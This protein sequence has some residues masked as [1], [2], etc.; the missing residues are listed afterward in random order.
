MVS[1][2]QFPQA[3]A[4]TPHS[5]FPSAVPAGAV[6]GSLG[7]LRW[8]NCYNKYI[9][10]TEVLASA[11]CFGEHPGRALSPQRVL[12]EQFFPLGLMLWAPNIWV[13]L[14]SPPGTGFLHRGTRWFVWDLPPVPGRVTG[15]S[16][17]VTL[18]CGLEGIRG[19]ANPP[20]P[21]RDPSA[22][23]ELRTVLAPRSFM[24]KTG[25]QR[26]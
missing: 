24:P 15:G 17:T 20:Q 7:T 1:P 18:S 2:E 11:D 23:S 21:R 9:A 22:E 8:A 6:M 19:A 3:L 16:G 26:Q 10:I 14:S 13:L 4:R 12:A 5:S 25:L